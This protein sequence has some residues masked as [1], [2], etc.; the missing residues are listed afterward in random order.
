MSWGSG[1]SDSMCVL[2]WR[3]LK[4]NVGAPRDNFWNSP[5]FLC[6][7]YL[8]QWYPWRGLLYQTPEKTIEIS[9]QFRWSTAT[10]FAVGLEL[11]V[12]EQRNWAWATGLLGL[13][14]SQ[15]EACNEQCMPNRVAR[16]RI[17]MVWVQTK[18]TGYST[19]EREQEQTADRNIQTFLLFY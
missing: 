5:N 7:I 2:G 18:A 3:G 9:K 10:W 19:C 14:Y 13:V 16:S 4:K 8:R 1:C 6:Y 17:H 11:S 15:A 12:S